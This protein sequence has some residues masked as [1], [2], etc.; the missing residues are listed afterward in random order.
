M[1]AIVYA[2]SI[3][4]HN[5]ILGIIGKGEGLIMDQKP[6]SKNTN[7]RRED[8]FHTF[9]F[10]NKW[11]ETR[12]DIENEQE[13]S[14]STEEHTVAENHLSRDDWFFGKRNHDTGK[15][16]KQQKYSQI[17]ELFNH[18]NMDELLNNI[19]DLFNS[20][21]HF[22]PLWRKMEPVLNKWMKP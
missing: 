14:K 5:V 1:M 7:D 10:G 4:F 3:L 11:A 6:K 18:V 21:S 15:E 22:K 12:S 20:I 9:M 8:S 19:D 17:D 13:R 16:N 2:F